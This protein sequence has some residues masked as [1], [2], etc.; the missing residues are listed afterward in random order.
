MHVNLPLDELRMAEQEVE[1]LEGLEFIF[2]T[3]YHPNSRQRSKAAES[4]ERAT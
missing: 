3:M 2:E 4:R 1:S